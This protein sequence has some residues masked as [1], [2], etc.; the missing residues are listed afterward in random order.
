MTFT[1]TQTERAKKI[2]AEIT[3]LLEQL[4]KIVESEEVV[5]PSS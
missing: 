5:T 4:A 1:P 2:V 3:S